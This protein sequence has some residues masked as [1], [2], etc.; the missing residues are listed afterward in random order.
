M[1]VTGAVLDILMSGTYPQ[2]DGL[3]NRRV[4]AQTVLT[5]RTKSDCGQDVVLRHEP[6]RAMTAK[7]GKDALARKTQER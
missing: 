7:E 4:K 6:T 5:R 2:A 1:D 3:E